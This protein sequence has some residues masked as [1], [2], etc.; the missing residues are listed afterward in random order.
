MNL[1]EYQHEA[2]SFRM[3]TADESYALFGLVGEVGEL[4]S[5][6]AKIVRDTPTLTDEQVRD[7]VKKELGDILWMISAIADDNDLSMSEVAEGNI[8][9]LSSRKERGTIQGSGDDR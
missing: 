6:I 9:K 2:M 8:Q 4:F 7:Y 3:E 1:N 5:F